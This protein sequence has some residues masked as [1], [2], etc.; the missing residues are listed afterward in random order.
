MIFY[1]QVHV[2]MTIAQMEHEFDSKKNHN[3][4]DQ[5]DVT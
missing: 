2:A 3:F 5:Q 4:Q 1:F